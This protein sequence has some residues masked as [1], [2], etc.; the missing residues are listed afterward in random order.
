ME[1]VR[2]SESAIHYGRLSGLLSA[3]VVDMTADHGGQAVSD[4][5]I[6]RQQ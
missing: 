2:F 4:V 5:A 3:T 1:A 6:V